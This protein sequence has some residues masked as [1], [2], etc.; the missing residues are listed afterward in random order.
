VP[1]AML[2]H[3]RHM[4][5][6]ITMFKND[7]INFFTEKVN[8]ENPGEVWQNGKW[9]KLAVE[10]E[11]I[12]V[13]GGEDVVF[14]LRRSSHGPIMNDVVKGFE[15]RKKPISMWWAYHEKS[16]RLLD[17]FY[18]FGRAKTVKDLE[19]AAPFLHAPGVNII[20]ADSEGNI[21]WWGLGKVPELPAHADSNFILQSGADE[22]RGFFDFSRQPQA[23]NPASGMI[24]S[25]NHKAEFK[26]GN[27]VPGYYNMPFRALRIEEMLNQ[28]KSGWTAEDMKAIQMDNTSRFHEKIREQVVPVLE[29]DAALMKNAN[30]VKALEIF[31]NW[32][33]EHAKRSTGPTIFFQYYYDLMELAF[34]DELGDKFFKLFLKTKA[35]E[36]TIPRIAA[37]MKSPWWDNIKTAEKETAKDIIAASWMKMV[38]VLEKDLGSDPGKWYWE[39]VHTLEHV[40][41]IGRKKPMN[42]IFNV[43]PFSLGGARETINNLGGKITGGHHAVSYGPS[44][45]RIIDFGDP[46]NSFGVS[47]V[48]QS[49]YFF[50]DYY[51]D[52]AEMFAK[53]EYRKQLINRKEIQEK[54][55]SRLLLKP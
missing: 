42:L 54:A 20:A 45:R 5:W 3:N 28:K 27:E 8:P 49:G 2:G 29:A 53:G 1:M 39:K 6:G 17:V 48:G 19:K 16:N 22:Y 37:N 9:E 24:V 35:F 52:Q 26:K 40:H 47:P 34:K 41:P 12:V 13:K 51:D 32:Q 15:K 50:D 30:A 11:R 43:G 33:G 10:K 21:G 14:D 18:H 23:V 44:T 25:C 31:K 38:T 7:D 4:G 46:E 36:N 55:K